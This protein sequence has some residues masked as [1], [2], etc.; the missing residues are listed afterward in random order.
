MQPAICRYLIESGL[1]VNGLGNVS[2]IR[3]APSD[4]RYIVPSLLGNYAAITTLSD[5]MQPFAVGSSL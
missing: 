4:W 1:D 5:K 3:Q 2:G